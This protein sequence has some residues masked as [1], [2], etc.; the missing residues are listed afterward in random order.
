M[1]L[2]IESLVCDDTL[3]GADLPNKQEMSIVA[4]ERTYRWPIQRC[5]QRS[6]AHRWGDWQL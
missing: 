1:P 2:M 5:F 6:V 4:S 3:Y